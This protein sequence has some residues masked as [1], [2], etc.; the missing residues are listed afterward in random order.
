[1]ST[2]RQAGKGRDSDGGVTA[3]RR[4]VLRRPG[5]RIQLVVEGIVIRAREVHQNLEGYG[6]RGGQSEIDHHLAG[7][8]IGGRTEIL[9]PIVRPL[10]R[11]TARSGRI[12][13]HHKRGE[14][15]LAREAFQLDHQRS[16]AA[17]RGAR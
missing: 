16:A 7:R 13:H 1:M 15:A 2:G 17:R 12:V 9:R 3:G 5:A 8:G 14:Q 6:R 11:L 10:D 4:I